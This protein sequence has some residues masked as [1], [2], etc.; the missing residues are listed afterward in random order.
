MDQVHCFSRVNIPMAANDQTTQ[1]S[2]VIKTIES[3]CRDPNWIQQQGQLILDVVEPNLAA[4]DKIAGFRDMVREIREHPIRDKYVTKSQTM[5]WTLLGEFAKTH[6]IEETLIAWRGDINIKPVLHSIAELQPL[7][8]VWQHEFNQL[9]DRMVLA[10]AVGSFQIPKS[11]LEIIGMYHLCI[12]C[13][14]GRYLFNRHTQYQS[15]NGRECIGCKQCYTIDSIG[16]SSS[17]RPSASME[18][19]LIPFQGFVYLTRAPQSCYYR[20]PTRYSCE[21]PT[22]SSFNKSDIDRQVC[23]YFAVIECNKCNRI[24]EHFVTIHLRMTTKSYH[25][26]DDAYTCLRDSVTVICQNQGLYKRQKSF[27]EHRPK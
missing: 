2:D 12:Y 1:K 13:S 15:D 18:A 25:R 6:S 4:L 9:N 14:N 8:I 17:N 26:S 10:C 3:F 16:C 11:L 24:N 21:F 27:S 20:F 5:P 7:A 22:H 19:G 23:Q